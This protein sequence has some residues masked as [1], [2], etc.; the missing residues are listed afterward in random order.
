MTAGPVAALWRAEASVASAA[1]PLCVA[2]VH[3]V[4]VAMRIVGVVGLLAT[5]QGFGNF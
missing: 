3:F 5:V 4:L 1:S 2:F